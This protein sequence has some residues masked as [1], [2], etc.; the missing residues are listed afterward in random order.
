MYVYLYRRVAEREGHPK[1]KEFTIGSYY[2]IIDTIKK[3]DM[4]NIVFYFYNTT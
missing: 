4:N 1:G 2:K 3:I